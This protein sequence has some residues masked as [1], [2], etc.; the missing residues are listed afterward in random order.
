MRYVHLSLAF[1]LLLP[2]FLLADIPFRIGEDIEVY[3]RSKWSAGRVVEINRNRGIYCEYTSVFGTRQDWFK[4]ESVRREYEKDALSRGRLW[5][6]T[7][8]KFSV[9][10]AALRVNDDSVVLRTDKNQTLNVKL[11]KLS[12]VDRAYLKRLLKAKGGNT[13]VGSHRSETATFDVSDAIEI[14][15]SANP[16]GSLEGD[17]LRSSLT[18]GEG[19]SAFEVGNLFDKIGAIIPLGGSDQWLLASL[20]SS[21]S[22]EESKLPTRLMWVSIKKAKMKRMHPLTPGVQLKDYYAPMKLALTYDSQV[23]KP[24]LSLWKSEPGETKAKLMLS[25]YGSQNSKGSRDESWA[26][27]INDRIVVFRDSKRNLI[28][29]DFRSRK[30]VWTTVQESAQAPSPQLTPGRRYLLIPESKSIRVVDPTAGQELARIPLDGEV[31][32]LSVAD[33]GYRVAALLDNVIVGLDLTRLDDV[34]RV[35]VGSLS[36]PSTTTVQW[37]ENDVICLSTTDKEML[38]FSMDRGIPLWRY[39]I[40]AGASYRSIGDDRVRRTMGGHLVYAA[41]VTTT[42]NGRT[43]RGIGVGAVRLP[44]E[45]AAGYVKYLKRKELVVFDRGETV[46]IKV[47]SSEDPDGIRQAMMD[48]AEANGWEVNESSKNVLLAKLEKGPAQQVQYRFGSSVRLPSSSIRPPGFPQTG[49]PPSGFRP[50]TGFGPPSGFGP[51]SRFGP[52]GV[53]PPTGTQRSSS[54]GPSGFGPSGFGPSGLSSWPF[55]SS[56]ATPP[57]IES[58]TVQPL[59]STIELSINGQP[60]WRARSSRGVP[61]FIRLGEGETLQQK[62]NES[63]TPDIGFFASQ[64][65]PEAIVNPVFREG[66]GTSVITNRGLKKKETK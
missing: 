60:A 17:P 9:V 64:D 45:D 19:G 27:F 11:E 48:Q 54:F 57:R 25:W 8:G 56:Q 1:V 20:E 38:L 26:R 13:A 31:K 24:I 61:P 32:S 33:D 63:Q 12:T 49:R 15:P 36:L 41:S 47:E 65:I 59:I 6:D 50:P 21:W 16:V 30:A 29:W 39:E 62:V 53:R 44:G 10:A 40:D 52:S 4:L 23:T 43:Q 3:A 28:A 7:E 18:L 58:A 46:K 5:K 22:R 14:E 34:K 66:L 2:T 35:D 51:S 42:Q 37:L 55:G